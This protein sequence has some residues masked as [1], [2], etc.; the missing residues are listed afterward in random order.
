MDARCTYIFQDSFSL[1]ESSEVHMWI[2]IYIER[3]K[4]EIST[5]GRHEISSRGQNNL[6]SQGLSTIAKFLRDS[7]ALVEVDVFFFWKEKKCQ[8][9][10]KS[11]LFFFQ[12]FFFFIY[13]FYFKQ[14]YFYSPIFIDCNL[15]STQLL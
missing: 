14:K 5:R 7:S 10:Y 13:Y 6:E 8:K 1:N 15:L 3:S 9:V 12:T 11:Y 2:L 4:L